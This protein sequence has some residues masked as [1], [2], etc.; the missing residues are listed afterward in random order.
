MIRTRLHLE[1]VVKATQIEGVEP[2]EETPLEE[3]DPDWTCF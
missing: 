2:E 3:H 1:R